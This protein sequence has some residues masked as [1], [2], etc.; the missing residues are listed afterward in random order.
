L[1][2]DE[3]NSIIN[4]LLLA[5]TSYCAAGLTDASNPSYEDDLMVNVQNIR[6]YHIF[7][8]STAQCH[9]QGTR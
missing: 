8:T 2:V 7:V 5:C 6:Y 4:S 9:A 1:L 3:I